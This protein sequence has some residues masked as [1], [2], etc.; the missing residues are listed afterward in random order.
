[1]K[2]DWQIYPTSIRQPQA[3]GY[4]YSPI[5]TRIKKRNA[6]KLKRQ[7]SA[8]KKLIL[9][10]KPISVKMAAGLLSRLGQLK[11]SNSVNFYKYYVPK[12]LQRILKK[13]I[14]QHALYA[15]R[16]GIEPKTYI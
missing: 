4:R 1:M 13:I 5:G 11:Q 15:P 10:H 8:C 14:K 2:K 9:A 7:L 16:W 3:M 6:L 12:G